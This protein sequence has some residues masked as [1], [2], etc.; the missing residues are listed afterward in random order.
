MEHERPR[1]YTTQEQENIQFYKDWVRDALMEGIAGVDVLLNYRQRI[2]LS[3][4]DENTLRFKGVDIEPFRAAQ[5]ELDAHIAAEMADAVRDLQQ[6]VFE[7]GLFRVGVTFEGEATEIDG[8]TADGTV[9]LPVV[10]G[11][12]YDGPYDDVCFDR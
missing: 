10:N 6:N 2:T 3:M 12:P 4:H 5:R 8:V 1:F 11:E 9:V 7:A